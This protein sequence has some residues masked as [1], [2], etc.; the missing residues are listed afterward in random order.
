MH[1][2]LTSTHPTVCPNDRHSVLYV[3]IAVVISRSVYSMMQALT[4]CWY[5][6]LCCTGSMPVLTACA[7]SLCIPA[8]WHPEQF[9]TDDLWAMVWEG[10]PLNWPTA[11][12]LPPSSCSGLDP[13]GNIANIHKQL[14]PQQPRCHDT[15]GILHPPKTSAML[16]GRPCGSRGGSRSGSLCGS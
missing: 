15:G 16:Q 14:T 2:D 4:A 13:A 6:L 8:C 12:W 7:L 10:C 9:C 5:I 11:L 1:A 3:C